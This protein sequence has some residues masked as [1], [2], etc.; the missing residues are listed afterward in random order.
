M[1]YDETEQSKCKRGYRNMKTNRYQRLFFLPSLAFLFV[2]FLSGF[3]SGGESE[4]VCSLLE[5]RTDIL[6]QA[7]YGELAQTE[8]ERRLAEIEVQPLLAEDIQSLRDWS[9]GQLDLVRHMECLDFCTTSR[10][11]EY[12]VC[13]MQIRWDMSGME[14]DYEQTAEYTVVLKVSGEQYKLSEFDLTASGK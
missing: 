2:T 4:A 11:Y 9:D 5:T 6:Q 7:Y 8:A 13:R 3:G 12:R 10:I 1:Y 14:A